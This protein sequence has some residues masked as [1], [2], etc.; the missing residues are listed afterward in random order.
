MFIIHRG[1]PRRIGQSQLILA[2]RVSIAIAVALPASLAM[3]GAEDPDHYF[4]SKAA[5]IL[6]AR[7]SA[8]HGPV[9]SEGEL[10]LTS[11]RGVIEG[12]ESG[13]V[14]DAR[15]WRESSLWQRIVDGDMPPDKSPQLSTRERDGLRAWLESGAKFRQAGHGRRLDQHD[16]IPLMLLRC[17]VCHGGRR[18]E[19]E[20]DLRTRESMLRGG[21]SGTAIVPGKP[22]ASLLVKRI[23]AGDMPPRRQL[24]KVSV[25]PMADAEL[26]R[27]KMWIEQGALRAESSRDES[28]K[29]SSDH[30]AFQTPRLEPSPAIRDTA[31]ADSI[32]DSFLLAALE[33][34]GLSF[35]PPARPLVWFRRVTLDLTGLPPSPEDAASF[36]ADDSPTAREQVVDRLLASPRYGERWAQVWLDAA[37]YADSEGSQNEDRI[38]E[39]MFR[40]RDY[41]I[42]SF[43]QDKSYRRFLLEQIAGDELSDYRDPASVTEEIFDNLV[44]TGFL[45]TAPDR[46]FA[47]IT[48]FVPDRLELVADEIQIL[49]S[50]VMGLTLHCARCHS[51][52]S[53][54][55]SLTDYYGLSALL[56]DAYD[57]HD[58][59]MPEDRK[60]TLMPSGSRDQLDQHNATVQATID[61][62]NAVHHSSEAGRPEEKDKAKQDKAKQDK[63]KLARIKAL[64]KRKLSPWRVRALWSRG[65]PSPTYLLRRGDYLKP[66]PFVQPAVPPV[67]VSAANPFAI[68]AQTFGSVRTTGRRLA[69]ANWLTQDSHPL[70][71]RVIVNRIWAAHFGRGLVGTLG[72]FG[73]AGDLPTHP[74]LLD[75]LSVQFM[76]DDWSLKKLHR[77][78]ALSRAYSQTSQASSESIEKDLEGRLLSR[79]PL[80]R[81][82]A[83]MVRDS[84]L[85]VGGRLREQPFGKADGV[86]V[87]AAGLSVSSSLDGSWRRSIYVLHRRTQM[88]TILENFDSPQMSPNCVQ[89]RESLVATQALHLMNNGL[90]QQLAE[91][92]AGRVRNEFE[93]EMRLARAFEL[94]AGR[95]PTEREQSVSR[96]AFRDF[97]S[98]WR[99]SGVES[100]ENAERKALATYC[101]SLMNSAAF[102]Y[103]D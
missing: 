98:A 63:A 65:Q 79:M 78:I 40:Y 39:D 50:A 2:A 93:P 99:E 91:H 62:L 31:R 1:Q 102:I 4:E 12:G 82:S 92:F 27:L 97:I 57:E 44:A 15:D 85:F 34:K 100:V 7:C 55:I 52:K 13:A 86:E 11:P 61:E 47:G 58:W 87:S 42:R 53:D 19:A 67:L 9:K 18:R 74:Q 20:L 103:I 38:R 46:T 8:C 76:R 49:G 36:L 3:G 80:R 35:S 56:K 68:E 71:A 101:H 30:W 37:G 6:K 81:M 21:K 16:V 60:L 28:D 48:N 23:E 5:A 22:E 26:R 43:N 90:V 75:S 83:E 41:V 33:K 17:A 70:T 25:K 66:G 14:L 77:R 94:V 10:D 95:P 29:P 24:V 64:E 69:L 32:I 89:R 72:N 59:L 96:R 51:H 73:L 54:P 84:L 45:R 88:P